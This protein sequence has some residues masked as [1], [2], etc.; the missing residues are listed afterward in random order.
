MR[1]Q[2]LDPEAAFGEFGM[3]CFLRLL[4]YLALAAFSTNAYA[5]S[6]VLIGPFW[7]DGVRETQHPEDTKTI[8]GGEWI[9]VDYEFHAGDPEFGSHAY[10]TVFKAPV[11]VNFPTS[12]SVFKKA[13]DDSIDVIVTGELRSLKLTT[14]KF[15]GNSGA[16]LMIE[17]PKPGQDPPLLAELGR[18]TSGLQRIAGGTMDL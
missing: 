9:R 5:A 14:Y 15:N 17:A 13:K 10:L 1:F 11:V 2:R 18:V 3:R 6:S 4:S 12:A 16:Q 8:G 7:L